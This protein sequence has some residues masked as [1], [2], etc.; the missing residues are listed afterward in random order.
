MRCV[1]AA[2]AIE[3]WR[4]AAVGPLAERLLTV[5]THANEMRV[6]VEDENGAASC[7]DRCSMSTTLFIHVA[8]IYLLSIKL[9]KL[10][11]GCGGMGIVTIDLPT[12]NQQFAWVDC[13]LFSVWIMFF[14]L[15]AA[16]GHH[17]HNLIHSIYG[18]F[19]WNWLILCYVW[20]IKLWIIFVEFPADSWRQRHLSRQQFNAKNWVK[21]ESQVRPKMAAISVMIR[22]NWNIWSY[23]V[24]IVQETFLE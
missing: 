15:I 3:I 16:S 22:M 23:Q 20:L 13:A 12:V 2:V 24:L 7:Q 4:W 8:P 14:P 6:A 19:N 17:L 18:S 11:D 10:G 1:L 9:C 5:L 21:I